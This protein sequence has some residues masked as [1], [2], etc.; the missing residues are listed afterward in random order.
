MV[1]EA[2]AEPAD[3]LERNTLSIGL[4]HQRFR[5]LET[6][7][8]FL[9]ELFAGSETSPVELSDRN[10][11]ALDFLLSRSR[12][13]E[14]RVGSLGEGLASVSS[15]CSDWEARLSQVQ[16][17]IDWLSS[18]V[19]LSD[20]RRQE[21]ERSFAHRVEEEF[22]EA[23]AALHLRIDNLVHHRANIGDQLRQLSLRVELLSGLAETSD[24]EFS[25]HTLD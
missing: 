10:T 7:L 23:L 18:Q 5:V 17:H 16:Q 9:D 2:P 24:S 21:F 19:S 20:S 15:L 1:S 14:T 3:Q 11:V 25:L 8:A 12:A 6:R 22:L 4:L 13:V